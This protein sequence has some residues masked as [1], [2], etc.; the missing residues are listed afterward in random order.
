MVEYDAGDINALNWV[1]KWRGSI[2]CAQPVPLLRPLVA[3][4]SAPTDKDH[5]KGSGPAA[6]RLTDALGVRAQ[7]RGAV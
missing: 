4:L 1:F 5:D 6:R 3:S 2:L 7:G